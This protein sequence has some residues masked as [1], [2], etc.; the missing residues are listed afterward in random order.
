MASKLRIETIG[1][2][3]F[4]SYTSSLTG[5]SIYVISLILHAPN[6]P[7]NL[8]KGRLRC[9]DFLAFALGEWL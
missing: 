1:S 4:P 3:L 8:P 2:T 7:K 9:F 5:N 6:V